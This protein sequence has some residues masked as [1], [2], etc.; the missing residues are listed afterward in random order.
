MTR[1]DPAAVVDR[2]SQWAGAVLGD[3]PVPAPDP[4]DVMV[5]LT[6]VQA[7]GIVRSDS[8]APDEGPDEDEEFE[9]AYV[10]D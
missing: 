7:T 6:I 1:R 3:R 2:L 10:V 8:Y 9:G 4:E 5:L